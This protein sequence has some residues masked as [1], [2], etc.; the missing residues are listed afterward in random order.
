M[1]NL[2]YGSTH[3]HFVSGLSNK[4]SEI[5]N[6]REKWEERKKNLVQNKTKAFNFF[7][8]WFVQQFFFGRYGTTRFFSFFFV[9]ANTHTSVKTWYSAFLFLSL[10]FLKQRT[11]DFKK[12]T[13]REHFAIENKKRTVQWN[14]I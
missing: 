13:K 11:L 9:K 3:L 10:S 1:S 8:L 6:Q 7:L 4:I 12:R 14:W 2:F 5:K